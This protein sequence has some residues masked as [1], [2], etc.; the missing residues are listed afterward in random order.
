LM[1]VILD[2]DHMSFLERGDSPEGDWLRERLKP[3]PPGERS[4]TIISYEEQMRGWMAVLARARSVGNRL[5]FIV[6]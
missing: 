2:T 1:T 6:D 3:I 5:R 4:T